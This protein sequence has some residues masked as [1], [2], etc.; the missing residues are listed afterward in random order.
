MYLQT[1]HTCSIADLYA[2]RDSI[3]LSRSECKQPHHHR[4]LFEWGRVS[5]PT[6]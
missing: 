4:S 3:G 6:I 2:R 5:K 1:D